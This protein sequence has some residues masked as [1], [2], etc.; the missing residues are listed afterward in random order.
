MKKNKYKISLVMNILIIIFTIIASIVMFTGFKFMK[1]AEPVLEMTKLSM[2]RFFTVDSNIFM[3]VIA[4][5]F[6]IEEISLLKNRI[7][8][9]PLYIYILKLMATTGVSLTFFVVF[10]YLGPFSSGGIPSMVR[11]SN[12]FFH[13]LTPV[14]SIITFVMFEK[15]DKI[16]FKQ[17][18]Y[19]LLPTG[20]YSIY[21]TTNVLIHAENG[22]VSPLYDWYWFMQKGIWT[23]VIVIPL[24]ALITF[25]ISFALWKANKAGI[26]K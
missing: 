21:Y 6:S 20:L 12:L 1:G 15:T 11:N 13:L 16:K 4:L 2:F 26:K 19:G 24:F 8:E 3:A 10:T 14:F 18:F 9:I 23:A 17:A 25:G 22:K 7:K 5:I